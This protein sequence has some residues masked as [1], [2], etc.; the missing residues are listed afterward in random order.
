MKSGVLHLRKGRFTRALCIGVVTVLVTSMGLQGQTPKKRNIF[1]DD[2]NPPPG[3]TN[4]NGPGPAAAPVAAPAAG[5]VPGLLSAMYEGS[6]T[7]ARL[8]EHH[9]T[10]TLGISFEYP[11]TPDFVPMAFTFQGVLNLPAGEAGIFHF[12]TTGDSELTIDGQVVSSIHLGDPAR[13]FE[14][15]VN[16]A[17]GIHSL[18]ATVTKLH[19]TGVRQQVQLIWKPIAGVTR[20]IRKEWCWHSKADEPADMM[21]LTRPGEGPAANPSMPMGVWVRAGT[22]RPANPSARPED[23]LPGFVAMSYGGPSFNQFNFFTAVPTPSLNLTIRDARTAA[24]GFHNESVKLQGLVKVDTDCQCAF[25]CAVIGQVVIT[26]EQ[27]V[28]TRSVP[29]QA[30]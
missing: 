11:A 4:P 26:V 17:A 20:Q 6:T 23:V 3:P 30:R 22:P 28:V 2:P 1:E 18:S 15:Q 21:V 7:D 10:P 13:T 16:L 9:L 12:D 25:D 27:H 8:H 24:S 29:G 19:S 5:L 14:H